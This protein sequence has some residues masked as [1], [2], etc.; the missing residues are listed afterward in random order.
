MKDTVP[1]PEFDWKTS[2]LI[3][4][5]DCKYLKYFKLKEYNPFNIPFFF[6]SSAFLLTIWCRPPLS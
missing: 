4:P 1:D 3:N 6:F 2:G 5:L